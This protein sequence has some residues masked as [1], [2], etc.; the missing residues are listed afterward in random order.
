M[1]HTR[2][3]LS[4][5]ML[6]SLICWSACTAEGKD[7]DDSGC[8]VDNDCKGDRICKQSECIDPNAPPSSSQDMSAPPSQDMSS[9]VGEDCSDPDYE[10]P[11]MTCPCKSG[12]VS[13]SSCQNGTCATIEACGEFCA[14]RGGLRDTS[15][16]GD[17]SIGDLPFTTS[18]SIIGNQCDDYDV[19]KNCWT[20]DFIKFDSE[21][22][23][24][25]TP[26]CS[27]LGEGTNCTDDGEFTCQRIKS[28][29]GSSGMYCVRQVWNLC[30]P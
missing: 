1:I 18:D 9:E 3:L 15:C 23:C 2:I 14:D 22:I 4:M 10:C 21:G 24:R 5:L 29:G 17:F 27:R 16:D 19:P 8:V 26:E 20:G 28:Y 13:Y 12:E 7:D 25:C 6:T 30:T 11:A